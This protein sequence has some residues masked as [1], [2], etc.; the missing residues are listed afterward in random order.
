MG[1]VIL[2]HLADQNVAAGI[3]NLVY[4]FKMFKWRLY[5]RITE[6]VYWFMCPYINLSDVNSPT[7]G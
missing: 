5:V 2:L 3:K 6:L 4:V 1:D 7:R